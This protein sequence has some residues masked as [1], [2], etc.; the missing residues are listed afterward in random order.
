M[1]FLLNLLILYVRK[2]LI[3][4][5]LLQLF[6]VNINL[7]SC[8]LMRIVMTIIHIITCVLSKSTGK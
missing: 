3:L 6:P 4:K 1:I 8:D 2:S 7:M 5:K